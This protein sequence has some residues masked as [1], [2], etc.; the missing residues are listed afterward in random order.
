MKRREK[1]FTAFQTERLD[2]EGNVIETMDIDL[3]NDFHI[4]RDL[5]KA[6]RT[7]MPTLMFYAQLKEQAH[8]AMKQ[9]KHL[10]YRIEE[11]IYDEIRAVSPRL[12]ETQVKNKIHLDKRW[13]RRIRKYMHWRDRY[14]MLHEIVSALRDR[15]ENLRTL[16]SSE[17]AERAGKY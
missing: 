12:S 6:L 1:T 9:Q 3:A 15:N 8:A 14:R 16:E 10:S 5:Q 2:K 4:G 11:K 7:S 13:L 17:R